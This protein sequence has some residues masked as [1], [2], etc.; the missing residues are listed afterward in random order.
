MSIS[1]QDNARIEHT[2]DETRAIAE[3][4]Y[5]YGSPMVDSHRVT[6]A[7]FVARENPEYKG[8]FD[9]IRNFARLM[10]TAAAASS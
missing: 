6:N 9:Q 2:P 1:K 5:I 8:P 10:E 4:A 7:Y 3:E